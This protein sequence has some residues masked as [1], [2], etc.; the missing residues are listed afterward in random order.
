MHAAKLDG[1]FAAVVF[2]GGGQPPLGSTA[3]PVRAMPAYFLLGDANPAHGAA[4]RLRD[5]YR[6]CAQELTW[7]LLPGAGHPSEDKALDRAKAAKIL[8]W[9]EDHARRPNVS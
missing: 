1:L 3:C 5:Y 2:H 8:E 6:R 7:E 9:L 4:V